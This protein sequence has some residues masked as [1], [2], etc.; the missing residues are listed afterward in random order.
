MQADPAGIVRQ[1]LVDEILAAQ[2][3]NLIWDTDAHGKPDTVKL[4][5]VL[6]VL[7][8][9]RGGAIAGDYAS[10]YPRRLNLHVAAERWR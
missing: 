3:D 10:I 6:G 9:W 5:G 2:P 8:L 7:V 4:A 1:E